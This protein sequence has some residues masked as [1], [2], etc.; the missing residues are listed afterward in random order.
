MYPFPDEIKN[1]AENDGEPLANASGVQDCTGLIP[2]APATEE[3][4]ESYEETYRFLP[5]AVAPE[6]R[7]RS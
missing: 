2:A 6:P 5:N 7:D 4:Y 1:P 3:E